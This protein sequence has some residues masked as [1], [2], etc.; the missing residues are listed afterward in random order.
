MSLLSARDIVAFPGGDNSS[1]TIINGVHLNK[2]T[3]DFWNYTLFSNG[4]LSNTSW[5]ILTFSPYT[6]VGVLDN[7]TFVNGSWCYRPVYPIGQR[8]SIGIGFASLYAISLALILVCLHKHGKLYLPAAKRFRP[9]GRRWQWYWAIFACAGALISL[10]T[11]IDVDRYFLPQ[12]PIVLTSFFWYL[13][14]IG[15][16]A[17]VWEAVRHW[18]SWMERQYIDPD[19]FLLAH[20]DRRSKVEFWIP[21]LFYFWLWMVC[22]SRLFIAPHGANC[23]P[24]L[25]HPHSS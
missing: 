4:T 15:S 14:Q 12:L 10:F 6:P 13:M 7:G 16:M 24:E 5:C 20:D 11:T 25:L 19:P 18:G 21:L 1:D 22:F 8:A 3:L 9:I 17:I 2:T 23:G